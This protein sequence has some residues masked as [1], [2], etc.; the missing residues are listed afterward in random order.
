MLNKFYEQEKI[1]RIDRQI[2][3]VLLAMLFVIPIITYKHVSIS[4]SP[5]F[6]NNSYATGTKVD[7][8]NFFKSAVLYLGTGAILSLF[9]YKI[10]FLKEEIKKNK[11]NIL[12]LILALGVV[13]STVFSEY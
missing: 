11:F 4:Y 13:L 10:I 2:M 5:V 9:I 12:L 3:F 6:I 7:V 8:F 1:E